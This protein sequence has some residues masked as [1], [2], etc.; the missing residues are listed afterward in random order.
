MAE[1]E[2]FEPPVPFQAQRFSRPSVSTAHPSL[3]GV[4]GLSSIVRPKGI[5][6]WFSSLW[7]VSASSEVAF[8]LPPQRRSGCRGTLQGR[9]IAV[10]F[11]PQA[12]SECAGFGSIALAA[13][14]IIA[15]SLTVSPQTDLAAS[16]REIVQ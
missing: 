12:A 14:G 9:G 15:G 6:E 4:A 10:V 13:A 2:G 5:S 7:V 11:S 16:S 3:R 1:G 8:F